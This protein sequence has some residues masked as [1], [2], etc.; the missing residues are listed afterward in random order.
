MNIS[1][2]SLAFSWRFFSILAYRV[3]KKGARL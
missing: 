3:G 2:N 1:L